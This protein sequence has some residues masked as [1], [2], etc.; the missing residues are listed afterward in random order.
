MEELP[1]WT[2]DLYGQCQYPGCQERP[3]PELSRLLQAYAPRIRWH[4]VVARELLS[5]AIDDAAV[6]LVLN[7]PERSLGQDLMKL[8]DYAARGR[9]IVTTP[10]SPR[11]E[12]AGG[13]HLRVC[14]NAPEMADAILASRSE[15]RAWVQERRRWAEEQRWSSRWEAWSAAVFGV[16]AG[17]R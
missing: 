4:G 7:R 17:P 9:P 1:E 12:Q 16:P 3:G 10:F 8:Y 15:P 14:E 11:L 2:L 6:A 13:P 5:R